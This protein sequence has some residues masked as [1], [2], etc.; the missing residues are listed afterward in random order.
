MKFNFLYIL[1]LLAC[2]VSCQTEVAQPEKG[3]G[4][5]KLGM[6]RAGVASPLAIDEDLALRILDSKGEVYVEYR[7]GSVPNKL[8]LEPGTFTVIAYTDNQN[9]WSTQNNGRGAACYYGE[10]KVTIEFDQVVYVDMQVP[11]MNYA[12]T[13]TL[14][15]LFHDLFKNYTFNVVCGERSV[16]I[17]ENEKAY[18]A[19][20]EKGFTYKLSATNTDNISH[21]TTPFTYRKV[22]TGKLYNITYYYGTDANS[23]GVDI[24]ITDDMEIDDNDVS[25]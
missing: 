1:M 15:D 24:E 10:C 13:L 21:S 11:M 4:T 5:L 22:E 7:A 12:V 17:K 20:S 8:I 9:S 14:P 19:V 23:G 6:T 16:N 18:F 3:T 2:L 25:L